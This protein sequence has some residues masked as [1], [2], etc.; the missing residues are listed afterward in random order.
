MLAESIS[1]Q[2][3]QDY[4]KSIAL[5]DVAFFDQTKVGEIGKHLSNVIVGR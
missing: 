1:S 5:K 3:R 4:F 2:V